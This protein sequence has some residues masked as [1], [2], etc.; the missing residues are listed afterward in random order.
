G[1]QTTECDSSQT[2]TLATVD[3]S[4]GYYPTGAPRV[5]TLQNGET[6]TKVY[7]ARLQPCRI[8][9]NHSGTFLAGCADA[10]PSNNVEDFQYVF[11]NSPNNNGDVTSWSGT[12]VQSFNR[13]DAYDHPNRPSTY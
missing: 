10:I 11:G 8:N 7:Q 1:L 9:V 3:P 13:T 12:G 6:E 4:V 5:M 2:A